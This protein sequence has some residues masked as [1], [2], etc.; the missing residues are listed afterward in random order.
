MLDLAV[1]SNHFSSSTGGGARA[2]L[3]TLLAGLA[4]R[5]D[6]S[7]DVYDLGSGTNTEAS[8]EH[9]LDALS[10]HRI[11]LFRWVDQVVTRWQLSRSLRSQLAAGY[12]LVITQGLV[13][14]AAVAVAQ[15]TGVPSIFLVRSL[16]MTGYEKYR[17]DRGLVAN[18]RQ[19]DLGGRMQYPFV[20]RNFREYAAACQQAAVTIANSEFTGGRL[21]DL[22]D[23]EA[24]VIYPPIDPDAYRVPYAPDG[25]I[26]MV[27]PRAEYKGL[28][29]FLDI[30]DALPDER[31]LVVGSINPARLRDRVHKTANVAHWRWRDDMREVYASSRLV[32]VPSRYEEPFGR[33]AAEAMVSGIPCV[34]SD[35]G[36]LPEVVGDTG[37][38]VSPDAS[39]DRWVQAVQTVTDDHDPRRQQTRARRYAA[40][41][42]V[43]RLVSIIHKLSLAG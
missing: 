7:V 1:V 11:P 4:E 25:S 40:S 30:A 6:I 39:I 19:T 18:L 31:F 2:S 37:I 38:A 20:R 9:T 24:P 8:F 15:D 13:A 12:D 35:R 33:V 17:P 27:N 42:Q 14:P 16:A 26:T 32:V 21:A 41:I 22:F 28:D 36:G 10:A 34:V 29:I 3:M 23:V 43:D 5:M